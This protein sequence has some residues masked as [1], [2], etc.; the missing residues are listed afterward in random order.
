MNYL[1]H[2]SKFLK[3]RR[4]LKGTEKENEGIISHQFRLLQE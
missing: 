4:L 3:I 1:I 2:N